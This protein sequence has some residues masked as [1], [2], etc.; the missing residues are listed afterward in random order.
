MKYLT[1]EIKNLTGELEGEVK[2]IFPKA[3]Q[4]EMR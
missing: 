3:E 4:K 2:E 1:G